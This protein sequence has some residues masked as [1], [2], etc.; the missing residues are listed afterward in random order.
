MCVEHGQSVKDLLN[1]LWNMDKRWRFYWTVCGTR[2]QH[3]GS[4]ERCVECR[5][6]VEVLL[7]CFNLKLYNEISYL[8]PQPVPPST[9][10]ASSMAPAK[11]P[12][13]MFV[14]LGPAD[15]H[16]QKKWSDCKY[17]FLCVVVKVNTFVFLRSFWKLWIRKWVIHTAVLPCVIDITDTLHLITAGLREG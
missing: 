4:T 3:G 9:I 2:P 7:N 11:E 5:N 13:I 14:P 8:K 16:T 1:C 12:M 15:T 10:A 6:S 17:V